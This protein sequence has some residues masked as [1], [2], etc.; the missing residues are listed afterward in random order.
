MPNLEEDI[1]RVIW[2][3]KEL[4]RLAKQRANQEAATAR[5]IDEQR[6]REEAARQ[7][8]LKRRAAD[9]EQKL[10]ATSI[11]NDMQEIQNRLWGGKGIIT[12]GHEVCENSPTA[13]ILLAYEYPAAE[14]VIDR[15]PTF[16]ESI[17]WEG[18]SHEG[19][20]DPGKMHYEFGKG[21]ALARVKVEEPLWSDGLDWKVDVFSL[22]PESNKDEKW[23]NAPNP[24]TTGSYA[25]EG[26]TRDFSR[27]TRILSTGLTSRVHNALVNYGVLVRQGKAMTAIT[28]EQEAQQHI[29]KLISPIRRFFHG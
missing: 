29:K 20:S 3:Q 26:Y 16:G 22:C 7:R 24:R 28:E 10:K 2:G 1:N 13:Y 17:D 27:S 23:K 11:I 5:R 6:E 25:E 19:I 9:L 8:E 21:R 14:G 4:E 18:R 15:K 12:S